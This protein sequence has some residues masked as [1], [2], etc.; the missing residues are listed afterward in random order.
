MLSKVSRRGNAFL[1]RL[2]KKNNNK[3]KFSQKESQFSSN[4]TNFFNDIKKAIEI[5]DEKVYRKLSLEFTQIW[6]N[7]SNKKLN[8][9]EE[10]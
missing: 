2:I 6:L 4:S 3:T 7:K 5:R 8:V 1:S 10:I 9:F